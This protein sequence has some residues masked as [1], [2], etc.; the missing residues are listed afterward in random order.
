MSTKNHRQQ[1][2]VKLDSQVE[3]PPRPKRSYIDIAREVPSSRETWPK[4]DLPIHS[5]PSDDY[6]EEVENRDCKPA[7]AEE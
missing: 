7:T 2:P 4:G 5:Q 6:E 1:A 3:N